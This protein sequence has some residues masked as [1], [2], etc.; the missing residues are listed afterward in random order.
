MIALITPSG[1]RPYQISLC[2]K[3]MQ[4]QT[5]KGPVVW[6]IVDDALP[7]SS[8]NISREGWEV[9]HVYPSPVWEMGQ[10]TQGR[11]IKAGIDAVRDRDIEAYFIIE[12]DDYYKPCYLEEMMLRSNNC[13]VWGECQT[14][15]YNVVS[16]HW[17]ENQNDKWS[18]LFQTA[19]KPFAL[20]FFERLYNEKFIDYAFFHI[21]PGVK[22]FKGNFSIGIKGQPGRGGIGAGHRNISNLIPDKSGEKLI[23]LLGTDSIYYDR[24]NSRL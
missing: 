20:S 12:D 21:V 5:Y 3:Y 6:V 24:Y 1:F 15:Y 8:S 7:C 10:N 2:E 22:L 14:I 17:I 4:A 18:S 13:L 11:N 19:F 23:E 16:R 9:I